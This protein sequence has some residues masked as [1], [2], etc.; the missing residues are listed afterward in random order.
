MLQLHGE[1]FEQAFLAYQEERIPRTA[2]VQRSARTW[3]E[4]IHAEDPV[5][6]LLRDTLL[7]Q[8]EAKEFEMIDWLYG[9]KKLPAGKVSK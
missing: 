2:K 6:I 3:G 4:I 8:K 1:N 9:Y 7:E 5:S